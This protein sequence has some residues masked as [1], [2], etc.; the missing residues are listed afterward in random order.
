M[1]INTQANAGKI[2]S[3]SQDVH[4]N[5]RVLYKD[6]RAYLQVTSGER[7]F[8]LSA[9]GLFDTQLQKYHGESKALTSEQLETITEMVKNVFFAQGAGAIK[10]PRTLN[11]GFASNIHDKVKEM[12]AKDSKTIG[13]GAVHHTSFHGEGKHIEGYTGHVAESYYTLCRT[14]GEV[15]NKLT[16]SEDELTGLH[17]QR[18]AV[19][20]EGIEKNTTQIDVNNERADELTNRRNDLTVELSDVTDQLKN[21][22]TSPELQNRVDE[23]EHKI[24]DLSGQ[25]ELLKG[26]NARLQGENDTLREK[27]S[28]QEK[29]FKDQLA[30]LQ[31]Q[32]RNLQSQVGDLGR[33]SES[34]DQA[35]LELDNLRKELGDLQN[36]LQDSDKENK[37]L[38]DD[39][40]QLQDKIK[41]LET[42]GGKNSNELTGLK[43][44]L[45]EVKG[46]L[47]ESQTQT[48]G[49]QGD[50]ENLS[51]KLEELETKLKDKTEQ[52][53]GDSEKLD[54]LNAQLE[55]LRGD[56][57]GA[58][59]E[60]GASN[61]KLGTTEGERDKAVGEREDLSGKLSEAMGKIADLE[62]AIADKDDE[63]SKLR[64]ERD[65]VGADKDASQKALT[66]LLHASQDEVKDL[67]AQNKDQ[68]KELGDLKSKLQDVEGS[69]GEKSGALTQLQEKHDRLEKESE[70]LKAKSKE[71]EKELGD[72][73]S[74]LENSEGALSE[75][76]GALNQLQDKQSRLEKELGDLAQLNQRLRT[77][78]SDLQGANVGLTKDRN[79]FKVKAESLQ[80]QVNANAEKIRSDEAEIK[81][82]KA[83]IGETKAE[84]R[85]LKGE[86]DKLE[87]DVKKL[88]LENDLNQETIK[89]LNSKNIAL[90]ELIE[91]D[92]TLPAELKG[93]VDKM[94]KERLLYVN[95]LGSNDILYN[96]G[97]LSLDDLKSVVKDM[98]SSKELSPEAVNTFTTAALCLEARG[99][100][101]WRDALKENSELAKKIPSQLQALATG[102]KGVVDLNLAKY[103]KGI[104]EV[105]KTFGQSKASDQQ[106]ELASKTIDNAMRDLVKTLL[107]NQG[108]DA[109]ALGLRRIGSEILK[110]NSI[111][112]KVLAT[113]D[114]KVKEQLCVMSYYQRILDKRELRRPGNALSTHEQWKFL[115]DKNSSSSTLFTPKH[116]N[117]LH[118]VDTLN[119]TRLQG[120][121]LTNEQMP[122]LEE[123][124]G[125]MNGNRPS[126][127]MFSPT[128]SG[129]TAIVELT[130]ALTKKISAKPP[131]FY[132]ISSIPTTVNGVHSHLFG[133]LDKKN[134][135]GV[136]QIN[137]NDKTT[138]DRR[139]VFVDEAHRIPAAS[140][141][142]I[143][144]KPA[145][146]VRITATP[147]MRSS[148]LTE[149]G[150]DMVGQVQDLG[151]R[152]S[153]AFAN[154][155]TQQVQKQH[156]DNL[157]QVLKTK[158][159]QLDPTAINS[160]KQELQSGKDALDKL[161]T[162]R[163]EKY[164]S[165]N[166]RQKLLDITGNDNKIQGF[167]TLFLNY[168]EKKLS[169]KPDAYNGQ[170]ET[171]A[172]KYLNS[173]NAK[174]RAMM[175]DILSSDAAVIQQRDKNGGLERQLK[176]LGELQKSGEELQSLQGELDKLKGDISPKLYSAMV[177]RAQSNGIEAS[178]NLTL[179]QLA[180][181]RLQGVAKSA[182]A[183]QAQTLQAA[184]S[185]ESRGA[186]FL[187]GVEERRSAA[188]LSNLISDRYEQVNCKKLGDLSGF[189]SKLEGKLGRKNQIIL[190]NF[191][192]QD[193]QI[194]GVVKQMKETLKL[195]DD[196][197][198]LYT[199]AKG[200]KQVV[201]GKNKMLLSKFSEK[202]HSEISK[203]VMLYDERTSAG[204]DYENIS[205]NNKDDDSFRQFLL[206]NSQT[207][208]TLDAKPKTDTLVQALGRMRVGS[209]G[210]NRDNVETYLFGDRPSFDT[211][212]D[213][214]FNS[215]QTVQE[216][217]YRDSDIHEVANR[218]AGAVARA[219]SLT[220]DGKPQSE[221]LK[222]YSKVASGLNKATGEKL[223]RLASLGQEVVGGK[224]LKSV[225]AMMEILKEFN[226]ERDTLD[227][228]RA[229]LERKLSGSGPVETDEQ[230]AD[231]SKSFGAITEMLQE[232]VYTNS[233]IRRLADTGA[234]ASAATAA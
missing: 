84:I 95:R 33:K 183:Q 234:F 145:Q 116:E 217:G 6:G 107:G 167:F 219:Y 61:E 207:T 31:E 121:T 3:Q 174:I 18:E 139:I 223:N 29:D 25:L 118:L 32:N 212:E 172:Q 210:G 17:N 153:S 15:Q 19:A 197:A 82:L 148:L 26:D 163:K 83:T 132:Y 54:D 173:S 58:Q 60:L 195:Q 200:A 147:A 204:G 127:N 104:S 128:G 34:G 208:D 182:F 102:S 14:F 155:A 22:P 187:A 169:N 138:S 161:L 99:V 13:A 211:A 176:E 56:L 142:Y 122:Q 45:E 39:K 126:A 205:K 35:T 78:V 130:M 28:A 157:R 131:E 111:L 27:L 77:E 123:I 67:K 151:R 37:R 85:S 53:A 89:S 38:S 233:A 51:K 175:G 73:R 5:E 90:K 177:E 93:L 141:I 16:L 160:S 7:R 192:V 209:R 136:F 63:I 224:P 64:A 150:S 80:D 228:L 166:N 201:V 101:Q 199:D 171:T 108:V 86:N 24:G 79:E 8:R 231:E 159:S 41:D 134:Q 50:K 87:T 178:S 36:K 225:D 75:K 226:L 186:T 193:G 165:Y 188:N 164:A 112:S 220:T 103:D 137:I 119:E 120:S 94:E 230:R 46:K 216:A 59:T 48:E 191:V 221:T 129:K 113:Y 70:E 229:G 20:Q 96:N 76:S 117:L 1:S 196:V 194:D 97:Q 206:L 66:D 98:T 74:K 140:E 218:L 105:A 68:Q 109:Q 106:Y 158:L 213:S 203:Y 184:V 40:G 23:L 222:L 232:A 21:D 152:Y 72:L 114:P 4:I 154:D 49:L 135:D 88:T 52:G 10:G 179:E 202:P 115:Y 110:P 162:A 181:T 12:S 227:R 144:G 55:K 133:E 62:R 215:L 125:M 124:F 47:S 170:M 198:F 190:P 168:Q 71:Q 149:K 146:N 57:A 189:F 9:E 92:P 214:L 30:Q 156:L 91:H 2:S 65:L 44:E 143:N 100:S 11:I 43:N 180:A 81:K 42:S 185:T 69:L